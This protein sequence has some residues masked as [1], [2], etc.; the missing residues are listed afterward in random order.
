MSDE[1][2]VIFWAVIIILL[3]TSNIVY[4]NFKTVEMKSSRMGVQYYCDEN[5]IARSNFPYTFN[6]LE[7]QGYT[8]RHI[9]YNYKVSKTNFM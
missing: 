7:C 1:S 2:G 5:N 9:K 8:Y 6:G 3:I 4:I